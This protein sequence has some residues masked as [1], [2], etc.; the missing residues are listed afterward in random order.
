MNESEEGWVDAASEWRL[1][2]FVIEGMDTH[3]PHDTGPAPTPT[4][5]APRHRYRKPDAMSISMRWRCQRVVIVRLA[6]VR[7]DER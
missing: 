2:M 3:D 4:A 1:P 6:G 5:A 7:S